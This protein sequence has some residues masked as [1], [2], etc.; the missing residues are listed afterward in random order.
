M[1]HGWH[2]IAPHVLLCVCWGV[3]AAIGSIVSAASQSGSGYLLLG[4]TS[5]A[6]PHVAGVVAMLLEAYPAE[7]SSQIVA[8]LLAD[9]IPGECC[10]ATPRHATLFA[11]VHEALCARVGSGGGGRDAAGALRSWVAGLQ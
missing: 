4:G 2:P 11:L 9:T 5:M 10:R 6:T 7:T 8:R 1:P 3:F